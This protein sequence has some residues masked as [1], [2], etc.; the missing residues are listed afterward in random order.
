MKDV[1]YPRMFERSK[2]KLVS[3]ISALH[4]PIAGVNVDEEFIRLKRFKEFLASS[5]SGV[6][7][8]R[9]AG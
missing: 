1:G 9:M 3:L 8:C 7:A 2:A 5:E 6:V 4:D